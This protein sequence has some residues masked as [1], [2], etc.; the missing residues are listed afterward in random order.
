[1]FFLLSSSILFRR[2]I[3]SSILSAISSFL[4]LTQHQHPIFLFLNIFFLSPSLASPL[5]LLYSECPPALLSI[6]TQQ[7]RFEP[8]GRGGRG[9]R[10]TTGSFAPP[11]HLPRDE[12]IYEPGGRRPA[13]GRRP[14]GPTFEGGP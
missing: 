2:D 13:I 9:L 1:M 3:F 12:W 5:P 11:P 14:A 8:L 6:S 4:P 10:W 7:N